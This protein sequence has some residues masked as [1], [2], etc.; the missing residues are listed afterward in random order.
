MSAAMRIVADLVA[1]E[2]HRDAMLDAL[3][4]AYVSTDLSDFRETRAAIERARTA[5]AAA[6]SEAAE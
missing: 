1:A 5:V 6:M 2:Q 3:T 4:R